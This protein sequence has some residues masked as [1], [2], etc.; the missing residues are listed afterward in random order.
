[1]DN[2]GEIA[3]R[4][5]DLRSKVPFFRF[6]V[7]F[8]NTL[9]NIT[10]RGYEF[11]PG[12]GLMKRKSLQG[13]GQYQD[14]ASDIIAKQVVGS[15]LALA[16]LSKYEDEEVTGAVPENK[17]EREAFYRQGKL[18]WSIKFG[19]KWISYRRIEPFNT[20]LASVTIAAET[21]KKY[22]ENEIDKASEAFLELVMG[23]KENF[24]DSTM[25]KGISDLFDDKRDKNF[26]ERLPG[27]FIPYS[28]FWRSI[29]RSL[30]VTMEG[31]ANA[32]KVQNVADGFTQNLPFG[33]MKLKPKMNVWGEEIVLEGGVLRQWLPFKYRTEKPDALE[34][35]LERIGV[36]PSIPE[37]KY[38]HY[39][40]KKLKTVKLDIPDKVYEEARIYYGSLLKKSLTAAMEK[41]STKK[42]KPAEA[43]IAY[44]KVIRKIKKAYF[45]KLKKEM[46]GTVDEYNKKNYPKDS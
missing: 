18:P 6:V 26:F 41:E 25:L 2:P 16:L 23:L 20:V 21:M 4:V 27:T 10:K 8:V 43:A 42:L 40:S 44:D 19:D 24:I 31:D 14:S 22:S 36:Y 5:S 38:N 12:L 29:N 13:K 15:V 17:A 9:A 35:E 45:G 1:M 33:T 39:D 46:K 11:V 3:K 28:S 7:P 32:R 37:N 30:E 34:K